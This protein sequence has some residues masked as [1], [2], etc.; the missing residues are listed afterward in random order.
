MTGSRYGICGTG[1][2]SMLIWAGEKGGTMLHIHHPQDL[3]LEHFVMQGPPETTRI[4]HTA[5]PGA[6][7][8]YFDGVYVNGFEQCRTGLWCDRLPK[9]PW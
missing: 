1:F 8:V 6:S 4:H 9:P 7:R 3:R 2:R 5:D